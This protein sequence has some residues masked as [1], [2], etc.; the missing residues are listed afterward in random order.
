MGRHHVRVL[1]QLPGV[2]LVGAADPSTIASSAAHGC[3][4]TADLTGLLALGID[5]CVV[6]TPT[7]THTE[8]GLQLAAAGVHTLIEKPLASSPEKADLLAETFEGA[9]L[10]GCVGHVERYNCA[11]RALQ[12]RLMQG[13]LGAIFQIATRRQ[14]PFPQRIRDVGVIMDL[15]THD[16]DLTA[17]LA[18]SP[19][20]QISA[21]SAHPS[22]R[23]YEDLVAMAGR[24]GDGTVTSHLVNWLSPVKER[25]VTVTGERGCLMADTLATELWFQ[26]NGAVTSNGP[27][28]HPFRGASEGDL[29]RYAVVNREALLAELEQ[30]RDAVLGKTADIVTMR[31]GTEVVGVASAALAA[32]AARTAVDLTAAGQQIPPPYRLLAPQSGAAL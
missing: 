6:A 23:A 29:T 18:G 13:D 21:V 25:V 12:V 32:S 9:G 16:I 19:Y 14:G 26:R 3:A 11:V 10:V 22:G 27:A 4:V 5:M 8:I 31:Q 20:R 30:F 15:A 17:W 2:D 1:S 28:D 24:L 7:L